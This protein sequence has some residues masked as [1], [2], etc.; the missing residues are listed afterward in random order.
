MRDVLVVKLTTTTETGKLVNGQSD[1]V[2]GDQQ[3]EP[4]IQES[5]IEVP[6][7]C[8]C[9]IP[10]IAA[11]LTTKLKNRFSSVGDCLRTSGSANECRLA[12]RANVGL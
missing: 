10:G 11:L 7:C 3:P 6:E 12:A 1:M 2:N 4:D 9:P 8:H 5:E